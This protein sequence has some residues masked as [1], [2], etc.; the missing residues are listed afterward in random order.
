MS[1]KAI[2]VKYDVLGGKTCKDRVLDL[3]IDFFGEFFD[4]VVWTADQR[5][6]IV[7]DRVKLSALEHLLAIAFRDI[8]NGI[9]GGD[10]DLRVLIDLQA[11]RDRCDHLVEELDD[12]FVQLV[13]VLSELLVDGHAHKRQAE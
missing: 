13:I 1:D 5:D 2:K 9:A 10:G 12:S 7:E 8:E 6:D 11:L 4:L 3:L